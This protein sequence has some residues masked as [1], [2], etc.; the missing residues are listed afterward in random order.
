[1]SRQVSP[2]LIVFLF[3]FVAA[4]GAGISNSTHAQADSPSLNPATAQKEV[5]PERPGLMELPLEDLSPRLLE[6]RTF[7]EKDK[8]ALDKLRAEYAAATSDAEALRL[9]RQIHE[10]KRG[11][12]LGLLK[13][14]LKHARLEGNQEAV[15]QLEATLDRA[16]NPPA[17]EAPQDRP[18]SGQNR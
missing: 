11:T 8:Q 13:I 3:L 1:M 6:I 2:M 12:E 9:Q 14:Q 18:A 7:L 10:I 15:T 17:I 16:S 5:T 4:L